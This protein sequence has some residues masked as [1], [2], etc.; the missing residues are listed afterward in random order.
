MPEYS[1]QK[2][3]VREVFANLAALSFHDRVKDTVP[4]ELYSLMPPERQ[5]GSVGRRKKFFL[6]RGPD[7]R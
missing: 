5:P 2:C 4:G 3:F 1:A 7:T 6:V